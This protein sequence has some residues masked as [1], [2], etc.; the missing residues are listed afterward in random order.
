V[1]CD[2]THLEPKVQEEKKSICVTRF[3]VMLMHLTNGLTIAAVNA[4]GK[5]GILSI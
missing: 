2:I 4:L 5:L 3:R 1:K